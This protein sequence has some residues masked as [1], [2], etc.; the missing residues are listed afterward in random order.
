VLDFGRVICGGPPERVG[1]DPGVLQAFLGAP[2]G[3]L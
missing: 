3:R 1:E 2:G